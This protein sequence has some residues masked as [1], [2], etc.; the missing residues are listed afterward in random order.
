VA[1]EPS[2]GG[3]QAVVTGSPTE[4]RLAGA[5]IPYPE[6]GGG[7]SLLALVVV[8]V[9]LVVGL[10]GA[11]GYGG[12]RWHLSRRMG[13]LEGAMDGEDYATVASRMPR[14]L[15]RSRRHGTD[16]HVMHAVSLLRLGRLKEA[17]TLLSGWTDG[18][19]A[20]L[21]YLWACLH[22]LEG[23]R[24]EAVKRLKECLRHDP[25]LRPD[26]AANPMFT[27]LLAELRLAP[28]ASAHREGYT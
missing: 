16:A 21:D 18:P 26:V 17:T 15:L 12:R 13:R 11:A 6:A 23:R 8:T 9:P 7:A 24:L 5:V 14:A 10:A 25:S 3:L 22:A 28:A 20:T 19:R 4:A 1:L 27:P 2:P